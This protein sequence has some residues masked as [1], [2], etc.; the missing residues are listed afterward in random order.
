MAV[1]TRVPF[2]SGRGDVKQKGSSER[3]EEDKTLVWSICRAFALCKSAQELT[4]ARIDESVPA[5]KRKTATSIHFTIDTEHALD[6]LIKAHPG[7]K[8][9]LL[10]SWRGLLRRALKGDE[11]L[12]VITDADA[13]LI[14]RFAPVLA[15]RELFPRSYFRENRYPMPRTAAPQTRLRLA[16]VRESMPVMRAG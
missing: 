5:S 16:P 9:D 12:T 13:R 8:Y 1:I 6:S 4:A 2:S 14:E 7:Q 10:A 15:A 3:F 11:Q